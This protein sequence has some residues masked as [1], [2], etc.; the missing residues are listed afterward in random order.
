MCLYPP[1]FLHKSKRGKMNRELRPRLCKSVPIHPDEV[2]WIKFSTYES[3]CYFQDYAY[4]IEQSRLSSAYQLLLDPEIKRLVYSEIWNDW[5]LARSLEY[6]ELLPENLKH[7]IRVAA[8][9]MLIEING[10]VPVSID[11]FSRSHSKTEG[12]HRLIA[13]KLMGYSEFPAY[14][15]GRVDD[16]IFL[17]QNKETSRDE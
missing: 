14:L 8:L 5:N 17:I 13:L 15:S 9:I 7:P 16:F 10:V 11:T 1:L 12:H 4:I 2:D 6:S 3:W